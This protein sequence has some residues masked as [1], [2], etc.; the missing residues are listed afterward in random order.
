MNIRPLQDRLIV[1]CVEEETTTAGGII[2]PDT[3]SKEKPQEGVII[4]AGKG[5]VTAEGKV[6]GMD[7]QVGDRVLFG[8]Y[9]GTEI[10]VD[11]KAYL[12]MREDDILG[13]LE[14]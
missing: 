5:K 13:V 14:K 11:G 1:E 3:A 2:I 10:K 9:A 8:K 7:V 4:A 12:M 6:L